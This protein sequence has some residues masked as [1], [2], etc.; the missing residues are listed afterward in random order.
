MNNN[1]C[2]FIAS[3]LTLIAAGFGFAVRGAILGDWGTQFDFT[4]QELGTITGMGFVGGGIAIIVFSMFTDKVG[5]KA[6]LI[7]AFV[8]HALSAVVTLAA[9]PIH[10]AMGKNATYYCLY[11]GMF[12]FS[13]ANGLCETAIN[14][15]VATLYR[16][17]KTHYLNMLHAGW[18]GGLILGGVIAYLFCGSK[19]FITHIPWEVAIGLFLIPTL[20]YGVIVLKEKF[21]ISEKRAA[22][23]LLRDDAAGIRV[24]LVAVA[25]GAARHGRLRRAGDRQLGA[26]HYEQRG[27]RERVLAVRVYVGP[28]VHSAV[29]RGADR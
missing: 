26:K 18:P 3:F 24:S 14:P 1:R 8:L 21:P 15:L 10:S 19:P 23:H 4:K 12:M 7:G 5:Y 25:L 27:R 6:I 20:I 22:A 2:L 29:L 16:R 28:D 9:T 13:L 11:W 17:K